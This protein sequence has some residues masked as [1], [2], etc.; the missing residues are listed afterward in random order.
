MHEQLDALLC[1]RYPAIFSVDDFSA[2]PV[3]GFECSDGWFTLIEA[4]C[5]LI[6]HHVDT[7]GAQQLVATQVK[8]KFGGLRFYY[9]HGGDYAIPVIG[10]VELLSTHVC[11]VCG[12]LGEGVSLFGWM[13][14]RCLEHAKA[15][16][17]EEP[18]MAV[19]RENL[20]LAPPIGALLGA[21][22]ECFALDDQAAA[23]WLTKPALALGS[24]AP[25]ALAGSLD[26]Q[27]QVLTLIGR[28]EHG[29][30]L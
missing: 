4:A 16:V 22:L 11:E 24:I 6:Q 25:L 8:E 29:I 28:L 12:A 26:G 10:L 18:L 19:I 30:T 13:Q 1:Q 17:Y 27:R 9:R 20:V 15:I 3:F 2:L 21:S 5:A 14:T 23:R 7:T